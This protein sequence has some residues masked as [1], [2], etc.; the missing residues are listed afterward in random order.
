M[1]NLQNVTIE[2]QQAEIGKLLDDAVFIGVYNPHQRE[3]LQQIARS[4][5]LES[6]LHAKAV[7]TETLTSLR[8]EFD[9]LAKSEGLQRLKQ[10]NPERFNT[11]W[12]AKFMKEPNA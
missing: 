1:K 6:C 7:I 2:R 8:D 11:L 10:D 3:V 5:G 4:N 12:K 9:R